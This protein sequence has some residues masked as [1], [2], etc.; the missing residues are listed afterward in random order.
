MQ[1]SVNVYLS[2]WEAD[3]P[4]ETSHESSNQARSCQVA[5]KDRIDREVYRQL[6]YSCPA[7]LLIQE[8][9]KIHQQLPPYWP[10]SFRGTSRVQQSRIVA[11]LNGFCATLQD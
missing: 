8:A 10:P 1:A 5:C 4:D 2:A 11:R 3:M 7:T 6:L 9:C